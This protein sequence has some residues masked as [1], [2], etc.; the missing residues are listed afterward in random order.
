MASPCRNAV[1]LVQG[2]P[3]DQLPRSGGGLLEVAHAVGYPPGRDPGAFLDNC[4]RFLAMRASDAGGLGVE[5]A[6]VARPG[7]SFVATVLRTAGR[8][9]EVRRVQHPVGAAQLVGDQAALPEENL[10]AK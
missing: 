4:T 6:S 1:M 8:S 9:P 5:E 2:R 3:G 10:L 7:A